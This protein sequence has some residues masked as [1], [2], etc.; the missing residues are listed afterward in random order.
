MNDIFEF[1]KLIKAIYPGLNVTVSLELAE[2]QNKV[3]VVEFKACL[4]GS[5][6]YTPVEAKGHSAATVATYLKGAV[7]KSR[8]EKDARNVLSECVRRSGNSLDMA[9]KDD[10]MRELLHC[11]YREYEA[12]AA[13]CRSRAVAIGNAQREA[14][15]QDLAA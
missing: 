7:A 9:Q 1:K 12:R 13:S 14:L 8:R 6:L 4:T 3:A 2:S 5:A 10:I 11:P 15:N